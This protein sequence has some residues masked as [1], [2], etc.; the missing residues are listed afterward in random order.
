MTIVEEARWF[1]CRSVIRWLD[2][3]TDKESYEERITIWCATSSTEAIAMAEAESAKYAAANELE[4]LGFTQ[5]YEMFTNPANGAEVFSL[6]R[7]SELQPDEYLDSFFDTGNERETHVTQP[8]C[9]STAD[10]L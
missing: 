9:R 4:D 7:D 10:C 1:A 3:P 2:L 6:I 5:V 8:C